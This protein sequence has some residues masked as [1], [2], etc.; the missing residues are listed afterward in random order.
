M[1][2]GFWILGRGWEQGDGKP[3]RLPSLASAFARNIAQLSL[4]DG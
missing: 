1:L 3:F 4:P 2:Q